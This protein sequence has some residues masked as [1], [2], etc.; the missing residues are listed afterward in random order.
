MK[1]GQKKTKIILSGGGTGGSVTPLLAFRD[2]VLDSEE[3]NNF[4]FIW[5]GTK[6]GIEKEMVE[7]EQIPYITINSGKLR[8]YFSLQNFTDFFKILSGY[9]E[10]LSLIRREKPDLVMS[11][12]GF[13]SVPLV[14]AAWVA[15]IPVFIHQQ[16]IR[17][18]LAN[19]L[20]APFA[21]KI[22]VTFQKSLE[23]Y[24][25]KAHQ[26]GN[27]IRQKFINSKIDQDRAREYFDIH[28]KKPI[29]FIIGGGTG[30]EALNKLITDEAIP[31]SEKCEIV[32]VFGKDKGKKPNN[33]SYH[34]YDFL[35]TIGMQN[36]YA[37]SDIVV[38]RCGL[39][40]LTELSLL[41]KPSIL[42]PMPDSHQ[43]DNAQIFTDHKAAIV[44]SQKELN[45]KELSKEILN[46][47]E[48]KSKQQKFSQNI[49]KVIKPNASKEMFKFVKD[50][51]A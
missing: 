26:I 31:L 17:P 23:D 39:G 45:S 29:V 21:K 12:G 34:A 11:A 15:R 27:P 37:I 1:K 13:V 8:R 32:H 44:L 38:S 9:F 49:K 28:S 16:D 30:S 47:I 42:I 36:A 40:V 6:K 5:V 2:Y 51:T 46:L 50:I 10:S 48:D 4:E 3:K 24:G 35:D 25:I 43:E 20:M 19:K 41:A 18:G 33:T 14:W 7:A 22:T